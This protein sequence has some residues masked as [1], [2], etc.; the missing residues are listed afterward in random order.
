[1]TTWTVEQ[2]IARL[3]SGELVHIVDI[4]E[5]GEYEDW[6]IPGSFNVPVYDT[7]SRG[8]DQLAAEDLAGV[9][10]TGP[11]VTVC[12]H[13]H[14]SQRAASILAERG[15]AAASLEGG[16]QAWSGAWTA[17]PLSMPD[18]A[19][20]VL[21][22]VRRNG[23]GCLSYLLGSCGEAAIVDPA[24][25]ASVYENLA[26]KYGLTIKYVLESHIHA[27][28]VS[29][30]QALAKE[31]GAALMLPQNDR[32]QFTYEPVGDGQVI[33]VGEV[34]MEV[35]STPGHTSESVCYLVAGQC[36]L[37]GDTVFVDAIGR[38]DLEKGDQGAHA[39]AEQLYQSL[40]ERVLTQSDDV[41]VYP[42]HTG[43]PVAFERIPIGGRLGTIRA[44]VALLSA[45]RDDFIQHIVASLPAK[46]PNF[47]AVIAVNEGR[48]GLGSTD[49]LDL[50]AG[51]N[52]CAVH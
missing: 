26:R 21:I 15:Q 8:D 1:M 30:A 16:M 5:A 40:H 43:L 24:V 19:S 42:G 46:P 44:D 50:E 2:L 18:S 3:E 35:L 22:Q 28:H 52:R 51:P 39:G 12:R 23:K 27:D 7:L 13:G 33:R 31:S 10:S 41:W 45:S 6:H 14:T 11:V 17:V 25:D 34:E 29:R 32:V 47:Q 36:L 4:R 49:P 20:A 37:S 38:P 48:T 9:S